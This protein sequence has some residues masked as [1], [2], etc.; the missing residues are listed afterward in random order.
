MIDNSVLYSILIL[1][2]GALLHW[3]ESEP[4]DHLKYTIFTTY[5][6]EPDLHMQSYS[7]ELSGILYPSHSEETI[8]NRLFAIGSPEMSIRISLFFEKIL[9]EKLTKRENLYNH[10]E[11]EI[12]SRNTNRSFEAIIRKGPLE[13]IQCRA[14][15]RC[16]ALECECDGETALRLPWKIQNVTKKIKDFLCKS[17]SMNI[18]LTLSKYLNCDDDENSIDVGLD[19][20]EIHSTTP[21]WVILKEIE[22]ALELQIGNIPAPFAIG[23]ALLYPVDIKESSF[24]HDIADKALERIMERHDTIIMK[25]CQIFVEICLEYIKMRTVLDVF[26]GRNN[27]DVSFHEYRTISERYVFLKS[28]LYIA[29]ATLSLFFR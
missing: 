15:L 19:N 29:I 17:L 22:R 4:D 1:K 24:R 13:I 25:S 3:L 10:L 26:I 23:T 28:F 20:P 11:M 14:F 18:L 6:I 9:L 7:R 21:E 16:K 2:D 12:E 27:T 8:Y 5:T